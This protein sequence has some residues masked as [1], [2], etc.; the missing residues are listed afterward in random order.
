MN[1]FGFES[2]GRLRSVAVT[3]T[4]DSLLTSIKKVLLVSSNDIAVVHGSSLGS[5]WRVG[6]YLV[7][8]A[9]QASTL[10][11]GA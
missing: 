4:I 2:T 3:V 5:H 10:R 1:N 7:Q 11:M 9:L 6:R 8:Q